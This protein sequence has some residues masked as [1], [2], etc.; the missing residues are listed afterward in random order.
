LSSL[1]L[2]EFV[3]HSLAG[4]LMDAGAPVAKV[5][6]VLGNSA[7]MI[8]GHYARVSADRKKGTL[9]VLNRG[10]VVETVANGG[11]RNKRENIN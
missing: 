4:Q 3:R 5:A 10:G 1:R 9:S 11:K 2:N 6:E 7:P 8:H